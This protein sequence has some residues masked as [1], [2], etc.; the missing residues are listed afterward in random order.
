MSVK[1]RSFSKELKQHLLERNNLTLMF[2]VKCYL[3]LFNLAQDN[4]LHA[5]IILK[6]NYESVILLAFLTR[7]LA[8][9]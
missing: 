5:P 2:A 1:Y 7:I 8:S 4:N 9:I 6:A 3:L